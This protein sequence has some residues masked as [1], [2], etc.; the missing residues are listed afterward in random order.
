[1]AAFLCVI[2]RTLAEGLDDLSADSSA[3]A[4]NLEGWYSIAQV[5]ASVVSWINKRDRMDRPPLLEAE[6]GTQKLKS[7]RS[8]AGRLLALIIVAAAGTLYAR[9]SLRSSCDVNAVK[10]TSTILVTQQRMYDRV[11]QVA[12]TA[13][14]N[15]PDHPVN[16][17]KLILMDTQ[18]LDVPGCMQTAKK[19]LVDY[20]GTV[21]LAFDAYRAGQA[22]ANVRDLVQQSDA[23]YANFRAQLREIDEC[24]PYCIEQ[25]LSGD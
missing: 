1:M 12:V 14:R 23:Q 9:Y 16:T 21:I 25:W 3:W 15:T 11:Y 13:L 19:E 20:M 4:R 24:A 6:L 7:L 22:D 18:E 2:E 10:E 17:L 8:L 5:F